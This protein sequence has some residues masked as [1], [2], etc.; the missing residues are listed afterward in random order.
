MSIS[1]NW[2]VWIDWRSGK[3]DGWWAVGDYHQLPVLPLLHGK[4]KQRMFY[5]P[6]LIW[7]K[8]HPA[9]FHQ[10]V[11]PTTSRFLQPSA[12]LVSHLP[13]RHTAW[14]KTFLGR[15]PFQRLYDT[16]EW[17]WPSGVRDGIARCC[18]FF[19][20]PPQR[21]RGFI[22]T[23]WLSERQHNV[24]VSI[25]HLADAICPPTQLLT[26]ASRGRAKL[27]RHSLAWLAQAAPLQR[28][29]MEWLRSR[30]PVWF[31]WWWCGAGRLIKGHGSFVDPV[32]NRAR[33]TFVGALLLTRYA[34]VQAKFRWGG[35]RGSVRSVLRLLLHCL[36][37]LSLWPSLSCAVSS[38]TLAE[39]HAHKCKWRQKD[40]NNKKKKKALKFHFTICR[41][42]VSRPLV[43]GLC[44][45]IVLAIV[46]LADA[47]GKIC[48]PF[49]TAAFIFILFS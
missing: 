42:S 49:A 38:E 45:Y 39:S 10:N 20:P 16:C 47:W 44:H 27:A 48:Y 21:E 17:T 34:N 26:L 9:A 5:S 6:Q 43:W 2:F 41:C 7:K 4:K 33:Y 14:W 40:T 12:H 35:G 19:F 36:S 25:L 1:C 29:S 8:K 3:T 32:G 30:C 37:H 46:C 15:S 18:V 28:A 13:L 22:L 11:S 23:L 24:S 31:W